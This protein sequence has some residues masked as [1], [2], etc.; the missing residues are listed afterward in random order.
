M[1][2]TSSDVPMKGLAVLLEALAK[3]RTERDD[4]ELVI[5]GKPK[6]RSSIPRA[7]RAA[8]APARGALR[9]GRHH[10]AHR[11]ALRRSRGRG[12]AVALRGLLAPRGRGDGVR[13]AAR[14]HHRRRGARSRRHARRDR[15]PRAAR[16]RRRARGDAAARALGEPELRARIGAAG[17][18][19]VL[20][21]FTWRQTAI[22]TVENYR[23]LL[24]EPSGTRRGARPS[25]HCR[26]RPSRR[27]RRVIGVL[28]LGLRRRAPLVRSDA[29]RRD[30]GRAR[31]R[32]AASCTTSGNSC[33]RWWRPA[34]S[35]ARRRAVRSTPTRS[36]CPSRTQSFDRIIASEVLEHIWA[37]ERA[38]A[39]LDRILRPGGQARGHG[40]DPLPERVCWALDHEYYGAPGG[41]IRIYRQR[42][43]EAKL[44]ARRPQRARRHTTPHALH[45]PYWWLRCAV[46]VDGADDAW[47]V[48]KY[49]D[50]LA[51]QIVAQPR[52]VDSVDRALNPVLGKSLVV[53]TEKVA[54][55]NRVCRRCR[56]SSPRASSPRRSTPSPTSSSPTATSRGRPVGTPT[57]GTSS[58]R[59]WRSTSAAATTRRARGVRVARATCSAPTA[60]GTPTTS[61]TRSRTPRSTPTS[62]VTSRPARGTTTSPPTTRHTSARS[63]RWSRRRS[64]MPSTTSA[65]PARS[66]GAATTPTTARCSPARRASTCR[67]KCRDRDRGAARPRASRLGDVARRARHRR[68]APARRVPR[69]GPLG[70]GL[71]LPH[72]SV[73]CSAGTRRRRASSS[74][75]PTFVVDGR[76]V[77]CVSD[78]PWVTAAETCEFVMALDAIGNDAHARL[79]FEWVQF[80]RADAGGYW[81]GANFEDDALRARRRALPGGATDLELRRRRARRRRARAATGRAPACS[82]VSTSPR[83]SPPTELLAAGVEI[84]RERA[85]HADRSASTPR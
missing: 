30:R 38:I 7:H 14:R 12:R 52:W 43:L 50:F 41:H 22:G 64:T 61:A 37:D 8:G 49:H 3:V 21:R 44:A 65:R 84:E 26:L 79:L 71:V 76:G 55:V 17:R 53:Y 47:P 83:A 74:G 60:A 77:R 25:A 45:S 9:V 36:R 78:R 67:L 4:V 62:L 24:E 31:R 54:R 46:G 33:S 75:W 56:A 6:K 15:A 11:R 59:R 35:R 42:D 68:R 34:I 13:R 29:A 72:R 18:A 70:D 27:P 48:R 16:R 73:A 2:T 1:T 23:A 66:R 20:D 69:Q 39:E 28:D 19:R 32:R 81:T 58:R 80:L 57:R 82:A 10:R 40:P 5:I 51:W 85:E 63:G